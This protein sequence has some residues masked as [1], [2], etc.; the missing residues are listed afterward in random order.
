MQVKYLIIRLL[1][2]LMFILIMKLIYS[3]KLKTGSS[4]I[5]LVFGSGF[6]VLMIWPA[7]IDFSKDLIGVDSWIDIVFIFIMIS[8]LVIN[9]HFSIVISG[10]SDRFKDLAQEITFLNKEVEDKKIN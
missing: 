9:I 7:L 1:S 5:W 2:I 3:N 8:L 4:W 6:L 10:L